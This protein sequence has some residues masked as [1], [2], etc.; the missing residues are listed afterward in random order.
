MTIIKAAIIQAQPVYYDLPATIT[1]ATA[2]IREAAQSGAKLVAVGESFFPGYP[3]WLDTCPNVALW[4]H[5]P[6]KGVFLRLYQ[7]SMLV[8][9]TETK[10]LGQLARELKVVLVLGINECV[11]KSAGHGTLY[12]S[13]LTIDATGE[14]VNHHRKLMPTYTER[15][16]WG[17]GDGSGLQAVDTAAG[18]VGG[19][20]CWEHWMPL[21][22]Q[23]LHETQEQIHVA[24][25]PTVNDHRHQ[26]ASRHYAFE[27]RCFVLAAGSILPASDL[28]AEL[29]KPENLKAGDLVQR[30]GSAIFAPD[31]RYLAGPCWDEET[32]LYA[33][34][35]LTEIIKESMALDVTGH[36]ARPDVFDFT[37][38]RQSKK[39]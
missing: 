19:L 6:T 4:D 9:G 11:E 29:T 23:A 25:W 8:P 33:D 27:G 16:V 10:I 31:G 13:L 38:N 15:M 24:V 5:E 35:D 39:P 14:I 34:L 18:R 37:V 32:I 21:T 26:V 17:Q 2:L 1:K 22:R 30:G 36:Y 3:V 7:N 20:I 12:N 28:P